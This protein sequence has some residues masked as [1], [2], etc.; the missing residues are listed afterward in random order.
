MLDR[1]ARIGGSTVRSC[2]GTV[3]CRATSPTAAPLAG[4]T[5]TGLRSR[6]VTIHDVEVARRAAQAAA[7]VLLRLRAGGDLTGRALGDAGDAAAQ[8]A[9]MASLAADRPDDVVFSEEAV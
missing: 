9:I 6:P 1:K 2:A 4:T 7:E 8:Q 3:A 5:P